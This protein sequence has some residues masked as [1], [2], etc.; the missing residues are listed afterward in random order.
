M[1]GHGLV[2][3]VTDGGKDV[4]LRTGQVT[5]AAGFDRARPAGH[6][7]GTDAALI[8]IALVATQRAVGIPELR[9]VTTL[10]VGAVVRGEEDQGVFRLAGFLKEVEQLTDLVVEVFHHARVASDRV[11]N[12][13]AGL[14]GAGAVLCR[15]CCQTAGRFYGIYHAVP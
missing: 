12:I 7:R 8:K 14:T 11:F 15:F 13:R 9:V 2:E 10:E 5:D 1:G 6:G 3:Q 4:I